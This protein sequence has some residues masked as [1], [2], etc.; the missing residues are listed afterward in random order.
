M[1]GA[2]TEGRKCV[3]PGQVV[4]KTLVRTWCRELHSLLLDGGE[5]SL[6]LGE[7][8]PLLRVVLPAALHHLVHVLRATLRARHPVTWR[9][10]SS[11]GRNV[12][13][14]GIWQ[15]KYLTLVNIVATVYT[16]SSFYSF[17]T[18]F[19]LLSGL[20]IGHPRVRTHPQAERLPEQDPIAPHIAL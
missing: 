8:G 4:A 5:V 16:A 7:L 19:H 10:G 15:L 2:N 11:R 12:G 3:V 13:G 6:Q 18:F 14:R 20:L 9:R 17:F 1:R